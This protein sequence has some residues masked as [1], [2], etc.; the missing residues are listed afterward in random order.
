MEEHKNPV[1]FLV[2]RRTVLAGLL[3]AGALFACAGGQVRHPAGWKPFADSRYVD[4]EGIRLHY[5]DSDPG[6]FPYPGEATTLSAADSRPVIVMIH[7]LAS[8]TVTW[9]RV[10]PLLPPQ[11][12]TIRIDLKGFGYSDK[13]TDDDYGVPTQVRLVRELLDFLGVKRAHF[14]GHS[15]G[16]LIVHSLAMEHP[17]EVITAAMIGGALPPRVP[18]EMP[19]IAIFAPLMHER[20]MQQLSEQFFM[21]WMVSLTYPFTVVDTSFLDDAWIDGIYEPL[22]RPG[23]IHA[24]GSAMYWISS[25]M[26]LGPKNFKKLQMPGAIVWGSEDAIVPADLGKMVAE[27][28]PAV[29]FH[30][31]EPA[32]HN[33]QEEAPEKVAPFLLALLARAQ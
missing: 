16:G 19:S 8:N 6:A 24:I 26:D 28:D 25:N 3:V 18:D 17:R 4:V 29:T 12:R 7:G 15:M 21:R 32:G 11:Y 27:A 30:V 33:V 2:G 10:M 1:R 23:S 9:D 5:R 20:K 31:V 22:H 14:M 13:P